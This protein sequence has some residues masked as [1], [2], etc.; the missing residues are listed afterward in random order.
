MPITIVGAFQNDT[1]PVA[2]GIEHR[3][4]NPGAAGSIP[5]G[6]TKAIISKISS[7]KSSETHCPPLAELEKWGKLVVTFTEVPHK[8][9]H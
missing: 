1:A 4:P 9:L 2:Q 6:G 8:P 5:A 7:Y 3:I